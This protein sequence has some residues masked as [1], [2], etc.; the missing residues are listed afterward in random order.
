MTENERLEILA[1]A[2]DFFA[3]KIAKN[4]IKNT[5]KLSNLKNFNINPFLDLYLANFLTGNSNPISIAKA[6]IYPRVLGTSITTSFGSH[7]QHFCS[8]V[9]PGFASG[10][11]GIDIEFDDQIDGNRKYC[12]TKAGPNTINK[13][14]VET[15]VGHFNSLRNIARVNHL[16]IG[17]NDLIIGVLY[18]TPQELSNHYQRLNHQYPVIVGRDFWHRLTGSN[19]FYFDLISSIVETVNEVDGSELLEDIIKSLAKEIQKRGY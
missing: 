14:D 4:H 15:I 1:K 5:K 16:K 17:I 10:I 8:Y 18:G 13:D 9:L 2:K 7:F 6:L 12:Q 3:E 11:S 19:S